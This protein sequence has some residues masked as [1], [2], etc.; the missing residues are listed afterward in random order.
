MVMSTRSLL[1]M[2][3][4]LLIL[5]LSSCTMESQS[6]LD[7]KTYEFPDIKLT[8]AT[9]V[10]G[11]SKE[12]KLTITAE[13][14]A[15]FEKTNRAELT[16]VQFSQLDEEGESLLSGR[17]DSAT[18]NTDTYDAK[19]FGNILVTQTSEDFSIEAEQ[20]LW[21]HDEQVLQSP[22]ESTV[23]ILFDG[24]QSLLGSGFRGE[25]KTGLY[26]FTGLTEGV[27]LK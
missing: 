22:E 12:P 19:L 16:Q 14:I 27:L 26:E 5:S 21:F 15:I 3:L 6:L 8:E 2:I 4:A 23:R 9:Y 13:E 18:V 1:G 11:R 7:P 17:A 24:G 20:L 25:L 10:L